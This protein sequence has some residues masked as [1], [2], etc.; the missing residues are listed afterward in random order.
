MAKKQ[1]IVKHQYLPGIAQIK[2]KLGV[3][4]KGRV[5]QFVTEEIHTRIV[6]YIP[7]KTGALRLSTKISSPTRITVDMPYARAQFFGVT[8]F[9]KPFHYS[10]TGAKVGSH[11][12]RRLVQ[13]EGSAIV[14]KANAFVKGGKS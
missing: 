4:E 8:K 10:N 7:I 11:W 13:N 14:A 6:D 2:N 12:D 3:D 1:F 5:Q 9:G